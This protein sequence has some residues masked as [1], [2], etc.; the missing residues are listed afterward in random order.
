M[1]FNADHTKSAQEVLFSCKINTTYHPLLML[2]NVPVKR[3]PFHKHLELILVSKLD[4]NDH[5]VSLLSE[6]NKMIA[7]FKSFK[8]FYHGTLFLRYIRFCKTSFRLW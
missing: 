1:S 5:L 6:V 4:F 7:R 2:H 3:V 8:M